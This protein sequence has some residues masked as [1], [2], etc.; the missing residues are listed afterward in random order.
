MKHFAVFLL[1]YAATLF[2]ATFYRE[3]FEGNARVQS[4]MTTT[5]EPVEQWLRIG[6]EF[7]CEGNAGLRIGPGPWHMLR[8]DVLWKTDSLLFSQGF[9]FHFFLRIESGPF[10]LG[11]SFTDLVHFLMIPRSGGY[12]SN[13]SLLVERRADSSIHLFALLR[14]KK[15]DNP[16]R[17]PLREQESRLEPGAWYRIEFFVRIKGD[18]LSDSLFINGRCAGQGA[19]ALVDRYGLLQ[20]WY[21]G[22]GNSRLQGVAAFDMDNIII[23][24]DRLSASLNPF[25]LSAH[26]RNDSL[27]CSLLFPPQQGVFYIDLN[28]G[29]QGFAGS[30]GERFGVYDGKN[31]LVFSL[32]RSDTIFYKGVEGSNRWSKT[33]RSDTGSP[34]WSID[35]TAGAAQ[36][37][38]CMPAGLSPG[39]WHARARLISEEQA[40]QY[41]FPEAVFIVPERPWFFRWYSVLAVAAVLGLVSGALVF[42]AR[43]REAA[44]PAEMPGSW[45]RAVDDIETMLL[46]RFGDAQLDSNAIAGH[47]GLSVKKAQQVYQAVKGKSPVQHLRE[48]RLERAC[49]L[50]KTT[51]KSAAEIAYEV[52]F[53]DP[54]IFQRNFKKAFS[55]TPGQYRDQ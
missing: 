25:S 49:V 1:L 42:R 41:D 55:L 11:Q 38:R 43:L 50:L 14:Q 51:Q 27:D 5:E 3:D 7:A 10:A 22:F 34:V 16:L 31:N 48:I 37:R 39:A 36:L 52:G 18:S 20:S 23:S 21:L 26:A 54:I 28:L 17:V 47:A 24:A 9:Y 45:K 32:Y 6:P 12:Y 29:A 19:V 8:K 44:L 40:A 46:Q 2:S 13:P 33:C 4:W 30:A 35:A 53:S 15:E